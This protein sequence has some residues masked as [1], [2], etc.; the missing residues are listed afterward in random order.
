MVSKKNNPLFVLGLDRKYPS[1]VI[2]LCHHS[3]S[4][5]MSNGDPS[6]QVFSILPSQL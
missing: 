4:L 2:T 6:E 1:L 3:P 5:V